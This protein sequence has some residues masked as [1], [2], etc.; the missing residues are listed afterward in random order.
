VV[1][2]I[3]EETEMVDC[4]FVGH[5]DTDFEGY[6][7][8]LEL[9]GG[10]SAIYRDLR[11]N[12]IRHHG[13]PMTFPQLYN[14]LCG[15][16]TAFG[17]CSILSP[18]IVYLA[19][20]IARRGFSFDWVNAFQEEKESFARKLR[21]HDVRTVAITTTYYMQS[22]PLEEIVRFVRKYNSK[23]QIIVGGPYIY[24]LY[25]A[26]EHKNVLRMVDADYYIIS[27]Q[28]EATLV[29]LLEALRTGISVQGIPN[30]AYRSGK[31]F[32]IDGLE[33]EVTDLEKD[34]AEWGAFAGHI[35]SV[36]SVRSAVSC[37][38][39]CSF[40]GFPTRGGKYRTSKAM[41]LERELNEL[42][43][44]GGVASI[45]YVD[46]T[47]NVP[48]A[49]YKEI[50]RMM[51][52]NN[53]GF[54][55]N[56]QYRCQYADRETVELMKESGCE[57]VFLGLEAANNVVLKNMNKEVTVEQYYRG[58]EL[59]NEYEIPSHANFIVGFPGETE[60]SYQDIKALLA[61]AKPTF[62][63]AQLWYCDPTT[64]IW[65][66]REKYKVKGRGFEW[67][68]ATMDASE[69]H[70]KVEELFTTWDQTTWT[71]Q[72]NFEF[73]GVCQLLHEG[74]SLNQIHR[75]IR[76]FNKGVRQQLLGCDVDFDILHSMKTVLSHTAPSTAPELLS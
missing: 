55:W 68:H 33:A 25:I 51:I 20:Y 41:S 62:Y 69:A 1:K 26:N 15:R 47:F 66:Q 5:N 10:D 52:R 73:Y 35:G 9:V 37:P 70:A 30:L 29:K 22:Q 13:N 59:L 12:F 74:L 14:Q 49:R 36:A 45:Q 61:E 71:P 4:I 23:C 65:N 50:M 63:R 42:Y 48:P 18:A 46:D 27:Q 8:N 67:R 75:L 64:P 54:K 39:S 58:L 16:S 28:G 31:A 44:L 34:P 2:T 3:K 11:L 76:Y 60:Q 56:C 38:F 19:S 17:I 7:A 53:Y 32:A 6:V 40:C 43:H 72:Y 24:S 21:N 57:G